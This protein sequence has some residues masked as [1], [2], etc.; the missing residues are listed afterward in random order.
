MVVLILLGSQSGIFP[1]NLNHHNNYIMP[2]IVKCVI[3]LEIC[4][5][6]TTANGIHI[7]NRELLALQN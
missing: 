4:E 2:C 7:Y 6:K 5:N 1:R 3:K